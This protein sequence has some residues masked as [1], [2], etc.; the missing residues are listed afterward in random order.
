M[1]V[2]ASKVNASNTSEDILNEHWQIFY[3]IYRAKYITKPVYS[4]IRN[5]V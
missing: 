4:N 2:N 3:S 1:I 5:S